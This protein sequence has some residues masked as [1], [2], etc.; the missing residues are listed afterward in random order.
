MTN[1]VLWHSN[2]PGIAAFKNA[3]SPGQITGIRAGQTTVYAT[4]GGLKSGLV[5][6]IVLV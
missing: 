5:S 1:V 2:D 6:V 4:L 3:S